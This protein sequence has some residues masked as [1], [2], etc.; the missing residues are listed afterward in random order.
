MTTR[1][2]RQ[3]PIPRRRFGAVG[4]ALLLLLVALAAS[5]GV[6]SARQTGVKLALVAYS[7]PKE[8]Y[9]ELIPAF[10]ATPA[11]QGITFSQSYGASGDQAAAV[12]NG[13]PADIVELSLAP[14]ISVLSQAGLVST[15]WNKDKYGGMVTDSIVVFV[16]RK[17]NPKNIRSWKDLIKPGVDVI[18][19]N[20]FTSGG[21][22][23]NVMAAYGSQIRNK[24]TPKQAVAFL[25]ALYS[26]ISV[27]DKSARDALNTFNSGKG[28]VLLAYEN[29]AI[30]AQQKGAQIDFVRPSATILIENPIAI[31]KNTQHP[32]EAKAF[33]AFLRSPQGQDIFAKRGY[34]PLD[35][36]IAKKW[37]ATYP[38]PKFLFTIRDII[39]GG[40]PVAQPKFFDPNNGIVAKIENGG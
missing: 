24:K 19:P 25:K 36:T 12:H 18:N 3:R 22:R 38:K 21:A 11:G 30:Q 9:A 34:R 33:V 35:P 13:L 2:N 26:H 7:T 37:A 39:K 10:Q 8:A 28:D 29:E 31:L 27:Q 17:G 4:A 40:W 32:D 14:D 20:P 16:V 1:T 6:A 23:W 5:A 15:N